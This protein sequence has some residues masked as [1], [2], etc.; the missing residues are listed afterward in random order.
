MPRDA[1]LAVNSRSDAALAEAANNSPTRREAVEELRRQ[2]RD[3]WPAIISRALF[4]SGDDG[5]LRS[6]VIIDGVE[7]LPLGGNSGTM[8][9]F[10]PQ[11]ANT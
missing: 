6:P 10:C 4:V 7:T 11:M 1:Y 2:G 9:V 3:A 5:K 8:T